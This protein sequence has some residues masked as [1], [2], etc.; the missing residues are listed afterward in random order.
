MRKLLD[1]WR[2]MSE[3]FRLSWRRK[4]SDFFVLLAAA[5][6]GAL[7]CWALL[8]LCACRLALRL[9]EVLP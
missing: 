9:R 4:K 1:H 7:A 5:Y 3:L 8:A 6:P 2:V